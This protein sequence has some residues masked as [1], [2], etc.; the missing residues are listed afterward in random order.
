MRVDAPARPPAPAR[1]SPEVELANAV[2]DLFD[3]GV[4]YLRAR[5]RIAFSDVLAYLDELP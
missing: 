4:D 1:Q 3:A 5:A 2:H